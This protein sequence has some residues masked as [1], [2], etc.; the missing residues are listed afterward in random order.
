MAPSDNAAPPASIVA[1]DVDSPSIHEHDFAPIKMLETE[2]TKIT[3]VWRSPVDTHAS[4][5]L[6]VACNSDASPDKVL[7]FSDNFGMKPYSGQ[8]GRDSS[9]NNKIESSFARP[10]T[11]TV[12]ANSLSGPRELLTASP[13][14]AL[15]SR[16]AR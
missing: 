2:K 9:S 11:T 7:S 5:P 16:E 8:R 3:R 12:I 4:I 14:A 6:P 10:Q 1:L 15:R 13:I